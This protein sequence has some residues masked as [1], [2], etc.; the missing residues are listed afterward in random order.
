LIFSSTLYPIHLHLVAYVKDLF[1]SP[2][3]VLNMLLE[4]FLPPSNVIEIGVIGSLPV[5]GRE[6]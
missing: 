3:L 1:S 2:L 4:L 5:I 6:R